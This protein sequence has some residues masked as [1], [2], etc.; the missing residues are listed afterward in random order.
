MSVKKPKTIVVFGSSRPK[1]SNPDYIQA[2]NLGKALALAG[3]KLANGGYGGT[4][5]GSAQGAGEAGG[6]SIGVTCEAFGRSGPNQWISRELTTKDLYERLKTLTDLGDGFVVLPG[7]TGTLLELAL[8]WE[9]IN[10]KFLSGV[11]LICLTDYWRS[12]ID[13]IVKSGQ[14]D[15][16][17]VRFADTPEQVVRL[18][19]DNL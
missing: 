10:K 11:P 14:T 5:A 9:L 19:E 3:F 7:S 4:M 15:G 2:Y 16:K 6:V 17:C 1:P 18:L 12:V 8:C 13:T